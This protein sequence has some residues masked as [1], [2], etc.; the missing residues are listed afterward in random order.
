VYAAKI[1]LLSIYNEI[2]SII[3]VGN[4]IQNS[5]TFNKIGKTY[6]TV[7]HIFLKCVLCDF[8]HHIGL[9]VHVLLTCICYWNANSTEISP[10]EVINYF[11]KYLPHIKM[12]QV[13]SVDLNKP[14]ILCYIQIFCTMIRFL[15]KSI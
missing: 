15:R 14:N 6:S 3:S 11:L 7:I 12:F 1:V 8:E 2:K 9:D 4:A 10:L 5:L 13:E